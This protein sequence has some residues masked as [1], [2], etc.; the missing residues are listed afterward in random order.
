LH[1]QHE[2]GGRHCAVKADLASET[3]VRELFA[4]SVAVH[5]KINAVINNASVFDYDDAD[6]FDSA[7]LHKHMMPNLT[8]PIVLA[9]ELHRHVSRLGPDARGV[10]IN[11]LDQKLSNL[12][13]D[14]L[15]YTLTKSALKTATTLLAQA[16][17]PKVRVVGISPGL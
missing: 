3:D 2:I 1:Q 7:M 10:V 9:Q 17:A 5:E 12:N 14:F 16:L 11:L 6:S 15:S 4:R 8:A 13:P